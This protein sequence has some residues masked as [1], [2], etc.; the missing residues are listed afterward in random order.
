MINPIQI[1]SFKNSYN[2]WWAINIFKCVHLFYIFYLNKNNEL[3]ESYFFEN[4]NNLQYSL[5]LLFFFFL[6]GIYDD[7]KSISAL[8]KFFL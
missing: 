7:K 3:V 4:F 6:I 8:K 2:N 5:L 1:E